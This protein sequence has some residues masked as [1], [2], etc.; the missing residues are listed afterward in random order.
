MDEEVLKQFAA[1]CREHKITFAVHKDRSGSG[2]FRIN[3]SAEHDED[4]AE[5]LKFLRKEVD[6]KTTK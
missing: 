5:L 3:F 4:I 6:D 2:A 1:Y